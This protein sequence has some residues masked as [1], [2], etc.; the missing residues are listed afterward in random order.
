[1]D[2]NI[3]INYNAQP[4]N[5][6]KL[7]E[8]AMYLCK[9]SKLETIEGE[10]MGNTFQAVRIFFH[11]LKKALGGEMK[12]IEGNIIPNTFEDKEGAEQQRFFIRDFRLPFYMKN[13]KGELTW[14]GKLVKAIFPNSEPTFEKINDYLGSKVICSIQVKEKQNGSGN[15]N[16]V[17]SFQHYSDDSQET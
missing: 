5:T 9:I 14:F 11:P 1:M 7:F 2:I 15:Y 12:D 13:G 16:I 4:K 8:P 3:P 17:E 10:Y 6:F